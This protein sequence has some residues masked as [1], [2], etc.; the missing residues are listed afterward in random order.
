MSYA[1]FVTPFTPRGNRV[2]VV[3]NAQTGKWMIPGG[4]NDRGERSP[5][6]AKREMEEETGWRSSNRLYR[7]SEKTIPRGRINLFRTSLTPA[8]VRSHSQRMRHFRS[9][10]HPHETSDYG[11]VDLRRPGKF[12][13][14]SYAG[15]PKQHSQFRMGSA[16]H[17]GDVKRQVF[18]APASRKSRAGG[19]SINRR[20]SRKR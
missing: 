9:R 2:M 6:A 13:V 19:R 11:F 5:D 4:R 7:V 3:Q 1:S 10:S 14:T 17:L 15:Q 20:Q 16:A 18:G 12:Q 8:D